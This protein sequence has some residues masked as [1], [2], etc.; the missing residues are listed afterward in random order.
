VDDK[1]TKDDADGFKEACVVAAIF[2]S[3]KKVYV[4]DVPARGFLITFESANYLVIDLI[5]VGSQHR[6]DGIGAA[7]IDHAAGRSS[8]SWIKAGTQADNLA[9]RNL[10]H[11]VGMFCSMTEL[12]LHK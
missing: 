9:A 8:K 3:S 5:A 4:C 6:G 12:T 10:Y 11:S 7:L 2:D 1:V